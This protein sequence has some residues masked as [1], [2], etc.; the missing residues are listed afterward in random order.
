M[1][2]HIELYTLGPTMSMLSYVA[3]YMGNAFVGLYHAGVLMFKYVCTYYMY[4]F[5]L[6]LHVIINFNL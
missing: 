3:T 2:M 4:M 6:L 5:T 1:Y